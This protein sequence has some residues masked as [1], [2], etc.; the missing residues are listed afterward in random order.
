M[1]KQTKDSCLLRT[2]SYHHRPGKKFWIYCFTVPEPDN[3]ALWISTIFSG[4]W[5]I[6]SNERET[7]HT[8]C[9]RNNASAFLRTAFRIGD[10]EE[11][12]FPSG[13][14]VLLLP[15]H[16]CVKS[17]DAWDGCAWI[18]PQAFHFRFSA[19]WLQIVAF[20]LN[21]EAGKQAG[22]FKR[23]IRPKSPKEARTLLLEIIKSSQI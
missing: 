4:W 22:V 2:W 17:G 20:F 12:L 21:L 14:T 6:K 7:P 19:P 18:L 16:L 15:A 10:E 8:G 13:T 9:F 5:E 1:S 23:H 3:F 11:E